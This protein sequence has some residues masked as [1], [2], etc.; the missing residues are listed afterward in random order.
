M[1]FALGLLISLAIAVFVVWLIGR[2]KVFASANVPVHWFQAVFVL[3]VI[4]GM[5]LWAIYTH[6]YTDRSTADIY[7][8]FDDAE[9]MFSALPHKP[10]DFLRMVSGI[11]NDNIYFKDNYYDQMLHWYRPFGS[12]A[13]NDT[14]A[15]IRFNAIVR[16]IS[17][18]QYPVHNVIMNALSFLGL[19]FIFQFLSFGFKQKA[20][21]LFAATFLLPSVLLWGS[22]VLKE[23]MLF[24][25]IGLLVRA[26][27]N[28]IYKPHQRSWASFVVAMF[29]IALLLSVKSYA[30]AIVPAL[31]A[32]MPPWRFN[33]KGIMGVYAVGFALMIAI[34]TVSPQFDVFEKLRIKQKEFINLAN[35]GTYLARVSSLGTDTVYVPSHFH[36][37]LSSN[38]GITQVPDQVVMFPIKNMAV[39]SSTTAVRFIGERFTVLLDYGRT[40]SRIDIAR[41]DGSVISTLKAMPMAVTNALLRPWPWQVD[42]VFGLMALAENA[43]L[44]MLLVLPFLFREKNAPTGLIAL[45]LMFTLTILTLTGLVTPVVGAIV[46]YKVPALPFLAAMCI[47]LT[48]TRALSG[49]LRPIFKI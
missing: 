2:A 14:H 29:G 17:F 12:S 27:A 16:L 31:L 25:G 39:D 22:G 48:D 35:G 34:S 36:H 44:L 24:L 45:C 28:L 33:W 1:T 7:K 9:V 13:T 26:C 40:G 10:F 47:H 46:R 49:Y 8:Y 19:S 18:G 23:G 32:L 38:M 11:G 6:Y 42:G 4:A 41:L 30:L 37:Q 20:K 43:I 5:A 3:K 15:I 21:A